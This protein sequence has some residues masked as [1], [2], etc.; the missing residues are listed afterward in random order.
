MNFQFSKFLKEKRTAKG[1]T[2]EQLARAGNLTKD[3][4]SRIERGKVQV[5]MTINTLENILKPLGYAITIKKLNSD[6][7]NCPRQSPQEVA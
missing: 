3:Y 2:Q 4:V 1:L 5:N 7:F 6:S